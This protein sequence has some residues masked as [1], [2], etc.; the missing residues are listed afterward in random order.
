MMYLWI[1]IGDDGWRRYSTLK[2]SKTLRVC[3]TVD[4]YINKLFIWQSIVIANAKKTRNLLAFN[5]HHIEKTLEMKARSILAVLIF[6]L[7]IISSCEKE[8]IKTL[9]SFSI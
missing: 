7:T 3:Y 4:I 9:D 8:Q 6:S 2:V 1:H 5:H